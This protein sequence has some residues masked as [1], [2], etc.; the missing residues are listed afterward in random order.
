MKSSGLVKAGDSNPNPDCYESLAPYYEEIY[1]NIDA[2]ETVR[3]WWQLLRESRLVTEHP[4]MLRLLD[5]GCGPGWQLKAWKELGFAVSGMDSSHTLLALARERLGP[6]ANC[7]DLYRANILEPEALPAGMSYDVV[8]SHFNFLN[9][10]APE[11]RERL[12]R[13][14]ARLVHPGGVW[15]VDFSEPH[16]PPEPFEECI[17]VSDG[18]LIRKGRFN[19]S[20]GCYE[21]H[22]E[23]PTFASDENYWFGHGAKASA[24]ASR[25][26]W[27]L[28]LRKAWHPY[29]P[30]AAWQDP[31]DYDEVLVD[32]YRRLEGEAA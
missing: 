30:E 1:A 13:S 7:A 27:Q 3:Q 28:C 22:W 24:L 5:I 14:V 23:G 21:Q 19:S 29:D 12:F 26:G 16:S 32:V 11:Q 8:V 20:L 9:L 4:E 31:G 15:I 25:T 17:S 2:D 6:L 10:F 18:T